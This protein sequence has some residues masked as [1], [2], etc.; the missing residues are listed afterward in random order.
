MPEFA[1]KA[2]DAGGSMHDGRIE[3]ANRDAAFRLLQAKGWAP[4]VIEAAVAAAVPIV[5]APRAV[6]RGRGDGRLTQDDVHN[7][8]SELS[9][10]LRAGL[11]LDRGLRVLIGMAAKASVAELLENVFK[12]VKAGKGL[13]QALEPHRALFGDFYVNMVRS[14]EVGGQ[15]A[16][17]LGR[18]AEHLERVKSL[19]ESVKSA[20][21]YPAILVFV[22][23]ISVF[24]MLGFVVPQFEGLFNDMGDALPLPTR[25]IVAAGHFVGDWW[26]LLGALFIGGG[27]LVRRWLAGPTGRRWWDAFVLRLPVLGGVSM[28]YEITRFARSMGTLLGNGVP[29]VSA[30]KIAAETMSNHCLRDAMEGVA[31]AIKQGVR[32]ATAL[33]KTTLFS[34]LALNMVRLGEETGKLDQMLLELAR[35]YDGEVQSGVKRA[36][37]LLEPLLILV[38]GA[39]IAAIIVAI[40]LGILSVN[41][42]AV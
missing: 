37:T 36:L 20:L 13:S 38:L 39:A 11:P 22:A 17:V 31:P 40:L 34:P 3:A 29:I 2:A 16:E 9:V 24:L 23:A 25:I 4:L 12:S 8:T 19:R 41:E 35:I 30:L 10:M 15:L 33:E 14:G 18:L 26:W 6:R 42:L 28:K 27:W 5:Q 32:V 21:I 1:Y 7:L